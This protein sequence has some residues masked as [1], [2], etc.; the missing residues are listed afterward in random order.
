MCVV[1]YFESGGVVE[2]IVFVNVL[3]LVDCLDVNFVEF[4]ISVIDCC[5]CFVDLIIV[6]DL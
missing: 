2:D 5:G 3:D 4:Y 1:G 6:D